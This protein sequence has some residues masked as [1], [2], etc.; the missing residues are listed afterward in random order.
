MIHSSLS[1]GS[2]KPHPTHFTYSP[3]VT[4]E[5]CIQIGLISKHPKQGVHPEL[6]RRTTNHFFRNPSCRTF[7]YIYMT[8]ETVIRIFASLSPL[9]PPCNSHKLQVIEAM[10]RAPRIERRPPSTQSVNIYIGC[11]VYHPFFEIPKARLV[12]VA[13]GWIR[14]TPSKLRDCA[15]PVGH[16]TSIGRGGP[17]KK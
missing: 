3:H 6:S 15:M 17:D 12:Y 4:P 2:A 8:Y 5:T 1:G 14:K 9:S 11:R 13:I 10:H 16:S 7:F